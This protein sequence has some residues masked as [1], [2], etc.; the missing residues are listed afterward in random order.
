MC[1]FYTLD[2]TQTSALYKT[3]YETDCGLLPL[4]SPTY[5]H[6]REARNGMNTSVLVSPDQPRV[7]VHVGNN[8]IVIFLL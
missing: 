7:E 6:V 1:N 8:I 2:S 3:M 5:R 4:G